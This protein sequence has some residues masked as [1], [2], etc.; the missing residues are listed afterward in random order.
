MAYPLDDWCDLEDLPKQIQNSKLAA[1][2][3]KIGP[4]NAASIR[5]RTFFPNLPFHAVLCLNLRN[6]SY[7]PSN[8][9][10]YKIP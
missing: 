6:K 4:H 10:C 8:R 1:F 2:L 9:L 3:R 5:K 7:S